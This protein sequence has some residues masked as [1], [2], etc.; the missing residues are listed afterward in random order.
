[1]AIE[2]WDKTMTKTQKIWENHGIILWNG[3]EYFGF[4]PV[5]KEHQRSQSANAPVSQGVCNA[6]KI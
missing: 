5:S 2:K 6:M 4:T 1:L 3:G